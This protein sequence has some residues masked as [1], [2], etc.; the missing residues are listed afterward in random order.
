MARQ[1]S[2]NS[3]IKTYARWAPVYDMVFGSVFE[4][5]RRMAVAASE[6]VGGRILEVGVGTGISLPYYSSSSR[7][8]GIDISERMLEQARRRVIAD[9]LQHVESLA[10]MDAEHL[11]FAEEAFDVV[12][13]QYVINTVPN[14]ETALDE[15]MRVLRSGGEL[16]IINRIGAAAGSR[17]AFEHAFQPI[18][19]RLGWR[20]EFPWE[21]FE[22]WIAR[23][24]HAHLLERRP[25][26]PLGH[27][28]L[29]RF[30]KLAST[31]G[32][33][34]RRAVTLA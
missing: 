8:V 27:F 5:A 26:P 17:R 32:S 4:N 24:P 31:N 29:I 22:R 23:A 18:A 28:A 2:R 34:Q 21:R 30:G 10:V 11:E 9:G 20:S 14:P 3:V 7:V 15:F 16:V 6:R 13:A 25:V 33:G 19:Q 12:V 1:L